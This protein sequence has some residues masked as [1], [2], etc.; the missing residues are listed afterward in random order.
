MRNAMSCVH[1]HS[2]IA[3]M[4]KPDGWVLDVGCRG[5]EFSLAVAKLGARVVAMD[6]DPDVIREHQKRPELGAIYFVP[7]ALVA[8]GKG[9]RYTLSRIADYEGEA[10][11]IAMDFGGEHVDVEG[12][13]LA[14]VMRTF[15]VAMWDCIKLDCEGSEYS[16][17]ETLPGGVADQIAVEFHDHTGANPGGENTYRRLRAYLE[18]WYCVA[19]WDPGDVLFVLKEHYVR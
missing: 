5:F 9:G 11:S 3:S 18:R 6:P 10:N 14:S 2:I 16:I 1:A 17:L 12:V 13:D 8:T 19:K 4:I 7:K 15:S